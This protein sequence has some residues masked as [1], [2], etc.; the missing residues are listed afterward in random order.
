MSAWPGPEA[1]GIEPGDDLAER[2]P[3][4]ELEYTRFVSQ[5]RVLET[6]LLTRSQ[7]LRMV[8]APDAEA[9]FRLLAETEYGPAVAS[10]AGPADYEVALAA[11]LSRV[12]DMLRRNAPD[13]GLVLVLGLAYDWQNL[14]TALKAAL[15]GKPIEPRHLIAAGQITRELL[16]STAHGDPV[17]R[18]PE[19]FAGAALAAAK[20]YGA[21][22]DPQEIDLVLDAYRFTSI[23]ALARIAGYELVAK[24]AETTADLVNLRTLV[25]LRLLR[26]GAAALGRAFVPGG[27]IEKSRLTAVINMELEEMAAALGG[28]PGVDVFAAGVAAYRQTSS[29]A[30]LEKLMDDR[31]LSL[32]GAAR[33]T[34]FGADPVIAYLLAKEAEIKNLRIIFTGKLNR[35]PENSIRERLRET[36]A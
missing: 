12:F 4:D 19:P 3:S 16:T 24:I 35:L 27:R 33:Y 11:E 10:A 9:A 15:T 28:S 23:S 26:A 29:L 7:L 30:V 17:A 32:V 25:R 1:V 36:Y 22:G 18:L 13:P 21:T 34:A 5:L 31:V 20:A 2:A 6:R 8:E 14:K